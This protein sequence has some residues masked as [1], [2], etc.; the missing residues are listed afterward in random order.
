AFWDEV[1]EPVGC[2]PLSEIVDLLHEGVALSLITGQEEYCIEWQDGQFCFEVWHQVS[3]RTCVQAYDELS[4]R[5][6]RR[7]VASC[8]RSAGVCRD[9]IDES[10]VRSPGDTSLAW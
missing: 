2:R 1:Q 4:A 10:Y 8:L 9:R 6:A 5:L 3:T 7:G